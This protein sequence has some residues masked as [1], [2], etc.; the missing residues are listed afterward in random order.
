MN[1][2]IY[3]K[4]AEIVKD[5]LE[6]LQPNLIFESNGNYEAFGSYFIKKNLDK[7]YTV[8]KVSGRTLCFSTLKI[9]LA[10]CTADK[11][12]MLDFTRKIIDLDKQA[13]LLRN[14]VAVRQQMIVKMS[15]PL[16]REIGLAKLD[17]KRNAL[18]GLENQLTKCVNLAKYWQIK[19][20]N[21]DEIA[22]PRQSQN[23]R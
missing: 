3:S 1:N 11:T 20:F 7:T 14:D 15:D 18:K 22:R 12:Q 10:W 8:T 13:L 6:R 16:R 19:G 9:A 2:K 4:L 23:T 17:K 21:R 5:D